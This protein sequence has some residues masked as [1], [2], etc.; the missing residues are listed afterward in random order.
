MIIC[1]SMLSRSPSG[2][3]P[4]ALGCGRGFAAQLGDHFGACDLPVL[5]SH[6]Q[7]CDQVPEFA[8]IARPRMGLQGSQRVSQ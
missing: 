1:S 3:A 6:G 5:R 4:L 7:F 8:D 2:T